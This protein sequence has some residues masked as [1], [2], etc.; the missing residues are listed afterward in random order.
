ME[1]LYGLHQAQTLNPLLTLYGS[2]LEN[3]TNAT[4]HPNIV[5]LKTTIEGEWYKMSEEF[6]LNAINRFEGVLIQ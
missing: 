6:I 2:V 4:F 5:S 1:F 3:K